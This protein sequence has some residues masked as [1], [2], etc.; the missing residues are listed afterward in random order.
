MSKIVQFSALG[1]PEVLQFIEVAAA[2]PGPGEVQIAMKA[3]GL[4]RAE[5]L[6]MAGTYLLPP[7]LPSRLGFE[8]A[9]EVVT[10]GVGVG[11]F[12]PGDRV[13]ITPGFKQDAYGVLGEVINIPASALEPIP[14]TVSYRDAA[15]FWM[16]F[17]TAYGV[18]VQCGRLKAGAGQTVLIN[19]ASSSVGVAAI[20][21]AR[22]HGATV[23][24]TTRGPGKVA[25]LKK[26]GAD[27]V[28][29]T[30][31]DDVAGRVREITNGHGFD[32]AADAVVGEG[33][34]KIAEA[35]ARDA[36]LVVYGLLSRDVGALPFG[37][38]VVSGLKLTGFHLAW[39]LLDVPE[40]RR[41]AVQH[42]NEGLLSGAYRPAI[43]RAFAFA[44]L[45]EAYAHMAANEHVGKIIVE[46]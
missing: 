10:V 28:I 21:I 27:H 42:L 4:N 33:L 30:N 34:A 3:A 19:A 17:G 45:R 15:A 44:D 2:P 9:A 23:I 38:M 40:R 24:A 16:A 22:A 8:G 26:A 32:I 20:Q 25:A 46:F 31:T 12:A 5:L 37:P 13:A 18:L 7:I 1:G 36:T 14:D 29:V 11:G 43:D 35:S 39:S 41:A 6:F